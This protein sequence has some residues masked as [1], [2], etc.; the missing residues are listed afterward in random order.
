MQRTIGPL[1]L[2]GGLQLGAP[3]GKPTGLL[4]AL[5][6]EARD[7]YLQRRRGCSIAKE[8]LEAAYGYSGSTSPANWNG[9]SV[10]YIEVG[11]PGGA[12][13]PDSASDW[14]C[15]VMLIGAVVDESVDGSVGFEFWGQDDSWHTLDVLQLT[16]SRRGLFFS[17]DDALEDG[18]TDGGAVLEFIYPAGFKT[19]QPAGTPSSGR[20]IRVTR[21]SGTWSNN[22]ALS[23]LRNPGNSYSVPALG[24]VHCAIAAPTTRTGT[25]PWFAFPRWGGGA[26]EWALYS[27]HLSSDNRD[28]FVNPNTKGLLAANAIPAPWGSNDVAHLIYLPAT[29]HL[30]AILGGLYVRVVCSA[31][32][33]VTG[34]TVIEWTPEIPD[35]DLSPYGD[36]PCRTAMPLRPAASCIFGGRPFLGGFQDDPQRII[37]GAPNEYWTVWPESNDARISDAGGGKIIALIPA[38]EVLYVFTTVGIWR[39]TLADPEGQ[40]ESNLFIDLVEE[41]RCTAPASIINSPY[42]ILFLASDGPRRFD[43]KRS[44]RLSEDIDE[45]F[46][47]DGGH[48]FPC[49]NHDSAVGVFHPL[50]NQYRISYRSPGAQHND[51][52]LTIDME[53]RSAWLHGSEL[54]SAVDAAG[55]ATANEPIG[56]RPWGQRWSAAC[57]VASDK[58]IWTVHPEGGVVVLD[59][60]DKDCGHRLPWFAE[61][62]HLRIASSEQAVMEKVEVTIARDHFQP[63][64]VSVIPDG[65]RARADSRDI[66]VQRDRLDTAAAIDG[67][68]LAG[69]ITPLQL[70]ESLSPLVWRGRKKA[71]NH[72]VRVESISPTHHPARILSV[73]AHLSVEKESR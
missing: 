47:P 70:D 64:R 32:S 24:Q 67:A 17:A 42:G 41:V 45:L 54:I 63:V 3:E 21:S 65:D 59:D 39:A 34:D 52:V 14:I 61:T 58:R 73:T 43:G 19:A 35:P 2:T 51:T 15:K 62:Q 11:E 18:G 4:R 12:I 72:R 22:V 20:W 38:D 28:A 13:G 8:V 6:V 40:N 29:D 60:G 16:D 23:V 66:A 10:T 33:W 57:W 1:P 46:R 37:W 36:I 44:K 26:P 31:T 69:N 7:G 27:F 53:G 55:Q 5:N 56:Q 68:S 50:Q 9:Q 25:G 48:A 49:L 30:L 71:R